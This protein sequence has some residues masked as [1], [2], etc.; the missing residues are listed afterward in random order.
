MSECCS[1][2]S[3]SVQS[4]SNAVAIELWKEVLRNWCWPSPEGSSQFLMS[5]AFVPASAALTAV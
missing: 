3:I 5:T 4:Q 1:D 2:Y